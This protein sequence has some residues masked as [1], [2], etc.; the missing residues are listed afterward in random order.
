MSI[1][2]LSD[3]EFHRWSSA[4]I[5]SARKVDQDQVSASDGTCAGDAGAEEELLEKLEKQIDEERSAAK[6]ERL[7]QE[8]A[9]RDAML[10]IKE[11]CREEKMKLRSQLTQ[12]REK[13]AKENKRLKVEHLQAT[14]A[15]AEN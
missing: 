3:R 12:L 7:K 15:L 2:Q 1:E 4:L 8:R 5:E 9:A 13:H 14:T 6:Q 11:E 10:E